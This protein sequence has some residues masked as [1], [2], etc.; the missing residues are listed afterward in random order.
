VIRAVLDTKVL[1]SGL[2]SGRA[3]PG[4]LLAAW[5][6]RRFVLVI[7]ES[8][9]TE[10]D[11]TSRQPYFTSRV[12]AERLAAFR[13]LLDERAELISEAPAMPRTATHPE[14]DLILATAVSGQVSYLVT[15]DRQL[16]KLARY[17]GVEIISPSAFLGM[18]LADHE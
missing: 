18:L 7:S 15:G 14:D 6:A 8:I 16:L 12:S 9:I 11:R 17:G 3:A 2:A 4:Q 5:N 1:A 13:T 10:L